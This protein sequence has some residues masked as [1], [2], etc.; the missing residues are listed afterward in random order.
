MKFIAQIDV[1][2]LKNLLDPQ[3]KAVMQTL[4]NLKYSDISDVR[5]GKHICFTV[6]AKDL[7]SAK[8]MAEEVSRKV[9]TNPVM[10][11]F[12]VIVSKVEEVE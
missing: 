3:G 4:H 12:K 9:L 10:E 2:P 1:M 6:D 11:F 5:I 7:E 8:Q